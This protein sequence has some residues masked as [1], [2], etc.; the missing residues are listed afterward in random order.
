MIADTL[1]LIVPSIGTQPEH[2]VVGKTG[3]SERAR[4]LFG[5]LRR[6]IKAKAIRPFDFHVLHYN[7]AWCKDSFSRKENAGTGLASQAALSLLGL[8]AEVSRANR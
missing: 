4:E 1:L 8:K 5:L 7:T 6:R 3:A 2:V